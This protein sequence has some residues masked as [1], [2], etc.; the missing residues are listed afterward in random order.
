MSVC[1]YIFVYCYMP[2]LVDRLSAYFAGLKSFGP[3]PAQGPAPGWGL[4]KALA[5]E[6]RRRDIWI[7]IQIQTN[8]YIF[9]CTF[10]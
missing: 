10:L 2:L 9:V 7:W 6:L 1:M 5:L 4:P 8:M 3:L